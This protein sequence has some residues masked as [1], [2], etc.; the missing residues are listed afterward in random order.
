MGVGGSVARIEKTSNLGEIEN[1]CGE[2]A[3]AGSIF[4][5][6]GWWEQ[7]IGCRS[8][9]GC[10]SRLPFLPVVGLGFFL[11]RTQCHLLHRAVMSNGGG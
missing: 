4:S 7:S 11:Y 8:R 9:T 1:G 10:R 5:V 3:W 2:T 6:A